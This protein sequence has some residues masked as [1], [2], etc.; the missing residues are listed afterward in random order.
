MHCATKAVNGSNLSE[1]QALVTAAI[2]TPNPPRTCSPSPLEARNALYTN[3]L[4]LLSSP[5]TASLPILLDYHE[6]HPGLRTARSYN[7]L[8]SLAIRHVAYGTVQFLL[9][10]MSVDKIPGNLETQKLKIRWFVRSGHWEHAWLQVST[11]HPLPIPLALWLE[12]FHGVKKGGLANRMDA[13]RTHSPQARFQILMQNLPTF[14]SNDVKTSARTVHILVRAMLALDKPQSALTLATRYFNGLPQHLGTH[15]AKQCVGIMDVLIASEA[16]KRGLLDFYAARRKL[17]AM[18]AIHPSFRPTSNTL[19][20]LL[21]TLRQAKHCG[22]VSWHTLSKFKTRW[23]PQ[24]ED[25]RVRRRVASYAVIERRL[26]IFDKV[27]E[28]E[29]LSRLRECDQGGPGR[30]HLAQA[31]SRRMPFRELF[32]RRGYEERLWNSL[33]MRALKLRLQLRAEA[34]GRVSDVDART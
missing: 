4:R 19:F 6:L 17:N 10:G 18:L 31:K 20:L 30:R 13:T 9:N 21:G 12:F 5:H 24:V 11:T 15:W 29:R 23:G 14:I 25:L 1:L 34:G 3:L 32:P 2:P 26:D 22:T 16:K 8:I 28:E 7:L 33:T 27:F